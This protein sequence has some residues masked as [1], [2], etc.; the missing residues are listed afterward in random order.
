MSGTDVYVLLWHSC[1]SNACSLLIWPSPFS[2]LC[3]Y[4]C[5]WKVKGQPAGLRLGF[6]M[7][8]HLCCSPRERLNIGVFLCVC[9]C[10][11][12][13]V[14]LC[15]PELDTPNTSPLHRTQ[16]TPWPR[17][18]CPLN[19]IWSYRKLSHTMDFEFSH[20]SCRGSQ[21]VKS[22]VKPASP[23]LQELLCHLKEFN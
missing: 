15:P 23:C 22:G 20:S 16:A 14:C 10:V 9:V 4:V 2:S 12:V 17:F 21:L 18:W 8:E 19:A 6:H 11:C 1:M 13:C 5:V 3:S 7:T